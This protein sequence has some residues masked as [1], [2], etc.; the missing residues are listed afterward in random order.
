MIFST[1]SFLFLHG[2]GPSCHAPLLPQFAR[3]FGI[4]TRVDNRFGRS[5]LSWNS[6]HA[7]YAIWSTR[8]ICMALRCC[9]PTTKLVGPSVFARPSCATVRSSYASSIHAGVRDDCGSS[10]RGGFHLPVF[11]PNELCSA[12]SPRNPRRGDALARLDPSV[13]HRCMSDGK[14]TLPNRN[15]WRRVSRCLGYVWPMSAA[16]R[17]Y[18]RSFFPYGHFT[19]VSPVVIQ[20]HLRLVFAEFGRPGAVRVDNG[21]PWGSWSDLPTALALWLI[22]LGIDVHWNTPN[23]PQENGVIERSQ[24]LAAAW[25]EPRECRTVH[26]LQLRLN[27]EDQIQREVY[28]SIQGQSRLAAFPDLRHSGRPY[29]LRWERVFWDWQR[30]LEHMSGYCVRRRIDQSGK[31]GVYHTKLYVGTMHKRRDAYLQFDPDRLEWIVSDDQGRQLRAVPVEGWTPSAVRHL[32]VPRAPSPSSR[33]REHEH[34]VT[35]DS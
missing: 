4:A 35:N 31:I 25:A 26:Q 6:H 34:I 15:A 18:G 23:R 32:R 12:G 8:W 3:R 14:W 16:A 27:H 5:L 7:P 24:G 22:G 20:R 28:P 30:V 13:R 11:P 33:N 19:Q 17:C 1:V 29:S 21:A 2:R 10:W 9:S